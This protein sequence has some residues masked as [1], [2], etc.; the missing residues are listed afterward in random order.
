MIIFIQEHWLPKYES[1]KFVSNF[2]N[3]NFSVTTS[4]IFTPAEDKML[5]GGPTWHGAAIGWHKSIE[6]CVNKIPIISE[7]FSGMKYTNGQTDILAYSAYLPTHGQDDEYLEVLSQ[8][9]FDIKSNM[10]QKSCILIGLDTNQSKKSSIRRTNAMNNFLHEFALQ[11]VLV[12]NKPTFHHNNQISVSQIDNILYHIPEESPMNVS[13]LKHLCKLE[14]FDNLSSHDAIIAKIV[15]QMVE[16]D[17][18]EPDYS[19][20]YQQ[21]IVP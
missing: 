16:D 12:N 17:S 1:E 19:T 21:F 20:T 13:L 4:D 5:E 2:P 8:L 3:Y 10:S 11:K 14:N 18:V 15:F 6:K 9:S 7:R